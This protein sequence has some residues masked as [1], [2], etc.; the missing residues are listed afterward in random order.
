[1]MKIWSNK[2]VRDEDFTEARVKDLK[3][4]IDL[5]ITAGQPLV[6]RWPKVVLEVFPKNPPADT[7]LSG[8]MLIVSDRLLEIVRCYVSHAD[9]E[10]LP[11]E[12]S[13]QGQ[14]VGSYYYLNVLKR[15]D[16]LDRSL[17]I[18]TEFKGCIDSIDLMVI[19]EKKVLG[20]D[21]F[22]MKSFE[23][24]VCV[25]SE[26]AWAII[27]DGITGVTFKKDQEWNP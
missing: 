24:V 22:Q 1:M 15:L 25:S 10:A 7:F 27:E 20:V 19:D 23:W 16:A 6:D 8:P 17:S 13:Y 11:V 18:F 14:S 3:A 4:L 21:L 9:I 5:K 26:L 12:V 2:G